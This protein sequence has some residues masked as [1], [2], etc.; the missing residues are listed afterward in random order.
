MGA[1]K[2]I[3]LTDIEEDNLK[4]EKE[5]DYDKPDQ[6]SQISGPSSG[7]AF[8]SLDF[9][10]NGFLRYFEG[11]PQPPQQTRYV[12]Q[13]AVTE[14]PE[15]P[16]VITPK[17][18]YGP[19]DHQQVHQQQVQHQQQ[20]QQPQQAMV[21]YLSNVPMQIYLV[22]QYYNE[23][24]EQGGHSATQY[25]TAGGGRVAGY[26]T[27]PEA[28][29]PQSNYIEV[30]T[31]VAPTQKTYIPQYSSQP[32]T[33]VS[34][35]PT[36]PPAPTIAPVL[37]YQLPVVQYNAGA[38]I[39]PQNSQKGYYP[40]HY[41]E[42]NAVEEEQ[43]S[44]DESPKQYT[45]TEVSYA[46]APAHEYRYYSNR[47]PP[48][49][50]YRHNHISELPHPNSLLLKPSP[51]HL[52]HIPKALP[53]YRPLNKPVYGTSPTHP[54]VPFPHRPSEPYGVPP[55]KRRPTSLL[56]SYVPSSL[57]IEYMKRGFTND[58][59]AAYEALSSGRHFSHA[60]AP[61]HY[62][63]GFLPNQMY[64]TAAGGVTF[65]HYKRTPKIDKVS[66]N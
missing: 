45:H 9:L 58:P 40:G 21:G 19:P 18:Q 48:R 57:Q 43:E 24:L 51:S 30:P 46:K 42:T 32:V 38:V 25:T 52:S 56:D 39:T 61:R 6:R 41:T 55:Y 63:R 36:V 28:V 23:G 44:I 1:E 60:P 29:Q 20:I 47:P 16:P 15:R 31:Y 50:E 62:E 17:S 27:L 35:A 37:A 11:H 54:P 53:M 66:Q 8:S 22:P 12:H 3:E 7:P 26:P 10:K 5:G 65:G 4:S 34:I 13:Y 33:Y 49:D 64:H 2:K 14:Q 59:I